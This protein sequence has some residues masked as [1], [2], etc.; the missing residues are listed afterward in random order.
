MLAQAVGLLAVNS[1]LGR[2]IGGGP[3]E[4]RLRGAVPA[5]VTMAAVMLVGALLRAA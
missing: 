3:I 1:V 4:D 5:L 2:L